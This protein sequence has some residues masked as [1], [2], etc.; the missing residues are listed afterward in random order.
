MVKQLIIFFKAQLS[1]FIG[2]LC[3]YG[4]MIFLTEIA[5]MHYLFSIAV[6]CILGAVVNFSLNRTW[7]FYSRSRSYKFSSTQQLVRFAFVLV[8]SILLK[9][10][11]TFLFTSFAGIDYKISRI[12][13][14][15][16]VS[17]GYNYVLQHF[18]VF[19]KTAG[20]GQWQ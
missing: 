5:G 10:A 20:S 4:I 18:W 1:A 8:S 11:G 15:M 9:I 17:L 19:K 16:I 13:T 3:D 12:I 14:D 6:A 7:S 2:G